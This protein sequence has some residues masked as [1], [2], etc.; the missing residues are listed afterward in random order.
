[1]LNAL[2]H[3]FRVVGR[4]SINAV[5]RMGSAARFMGLVLLRSGPSLRRFHLTI[6][7]LHFAGTLSLIIIVVSGMFVGLV[8]GLQG[9]ETLKRYGS[10]EALGTL[11]AR[12]LVRARG[13]VVSALFSGSRAGSAITAKIGIMKAT[14]QLGAME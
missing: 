10:A 3:G 2:S 1:M 14:E 6:D 12:A 5:W 7:E 13:P 9:Y 4:R 8:L 11:V